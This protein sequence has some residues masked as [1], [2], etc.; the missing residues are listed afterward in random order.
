MGM[1]FLAKAIQ[2]FQGGTDEVG[3]S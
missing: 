3:M 2:H 1:Q